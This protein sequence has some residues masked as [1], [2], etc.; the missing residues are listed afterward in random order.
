MDVDFGK[1]AQDYTRHR[2]G[3][4][5]SLFERLAARGIGAPGQRLLD[6]GCGTGSLALGFAA[7]GAQVTGIDRAPEMVEA[8][9]QRAEQAGLE[10]SFRVA[11]AEQTELPAKIFDAVTAGQCWHWFDRPRAGAELRRLLAPGGRVAICHFDWLP[12]AE[13]A[14]AATEQLIQMHNPFWT[15]SGGTG[16]YPEWLTDLSAAGFREIESFSY[17]CEIAYSH[18]DWRGRIRASAGIGGSLGE[19]DVAAFD[20]ALEALLKRRFPEDPL[21][22]PHRVFTALG[23]AP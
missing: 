8:A 6:L 23:Q 1:T 15:L 5:D 9:R 12:L 19:T 13:N 7:R 4:P 18:A 14:V 3:F 17:D 22:L 10:V 20:A 21:K 16:V 2:A 11:P